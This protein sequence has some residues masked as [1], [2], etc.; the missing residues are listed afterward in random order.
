M[1]WTRAQIPHCGTS[2]CHWRRV[3]DSTHAVGCTCSNPQCVLL[4]PPGHVDAGA[5]E[6]REECLGES[7]AGWYCCRECIGERAGRARKGWGGRKG[8]AAQRYDVSL[9]PTADGRWTRWWAA[10]GV[11]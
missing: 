10:V 1:G 4:P 11:A 8:A 6:Q 9:T 3:L 2:R 7:G 5:A